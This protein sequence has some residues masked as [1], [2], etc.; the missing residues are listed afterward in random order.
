MASIRLEQKIPGVPAGA[1]GCRIQGLQ[2]AKSGRWDPWL[3]VVKKSQLFRQHAHSPG[4]ARAQRMVLPQRRIGRQLS[5]LY[6]VGHCA[7]WDWEH[8][9]L[10]SGSGQ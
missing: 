9:C 10:S 7:L 4:I 8:C 6:I 2:G 3:Q 1:V 5:A